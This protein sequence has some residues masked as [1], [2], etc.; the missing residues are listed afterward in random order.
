MTNTVRI[1]YI[2]NI[3]KYHYQITLT[4][5]KIVSFKLNVVSSILMK[6]N[7]NQ[8]KSLLASISLVLHLSPKST[9][10]SKLKFCCI[11]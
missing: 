11:N 6:E 10:M 1:N 4:T 8:F 9:E 7:D 3:I 5:R 2:N